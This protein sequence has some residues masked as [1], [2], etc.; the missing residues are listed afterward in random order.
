MNCKCIDISG[1]TPTTQFPKCP[2]RHPSTE[3]C[4]TDKLCI[5]SPS[6]N[7]FEI[8]EVSVTLLICSSKIIC[9]PTG[10]KVIVEGIKK[11]KVTFAADD[12]CH[13][14]HCANFEV[15]FCSLIILGSLTDE[16]AQ[17]TWAIEHISVRCLDCRCL[18]VT[19]VILI[20][21]EFERPPICP[22]QHGQW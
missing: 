19:T 12:P 6:P 17:I 10:R 4:E 16:I 13:S 9:N 22:Q 8:I 15:P 5:P 21:P 14:V 2:P 11:I 1:I 18:A 7:I 20:C 3:F